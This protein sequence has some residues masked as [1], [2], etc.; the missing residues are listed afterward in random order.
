MQKEET[1]ECMN[2]KRNKKQKL[3]KTPSLHHL[4]TYH[5]RITTSFTKSG[6]VSSSVEQKGR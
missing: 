3:K 1:L 4:T 6:Q 5:P 2:Q